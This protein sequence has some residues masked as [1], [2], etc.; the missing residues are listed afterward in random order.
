MSAHQT[1][2][3]RDAKRYE[4]GTSQNGP[5]K[6]PFSYIILIAPVYI[7]CGSAVGVNSSEMRKSIW[8]DCIDSA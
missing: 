4:Q 6:T 5:Q 8:K 1:N 7:S 3:S 2:H